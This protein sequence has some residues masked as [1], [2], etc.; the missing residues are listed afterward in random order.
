MN[1]TIDS[2]TAGPSP[3]FARKRLKTPGPAP[4]DPLTGL[5]EMPDSEQLA[6]EPWDEFHPPPEDLLEAFPWEPDAAASPEICDGPTECVDLPG[7]RFVIEDAGGSD[8]LPVALNRS[9]TRVFGIPGRAVA[10]ELPLFAGP[11]GGTVGRFVIIRAAPKTPGGDGGLFWTREGGPGYVLPN[12]IG[13]PQFDGID[14]V[15][16]FGNPIDAFRYDFAFTDG[17]GHGG[18]PDG[19]N[20]SVV[21][22]GW[23]G[24]PPTPG[25]L[26]RN[27]GNSSD[28]IGAY[29][30]GRGETD[31][32]AD[33]F[34][35]GAATAAAGDAPFRIAALGGGGEPASAG[36]GGG[37]VE[38]LLVG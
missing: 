12:L 4:S 22:A 8:R 34:L 18:P 30:P 16:W 33:E 23:S 9:A 19:R 1:R 25:L 13:R 5:P 3:A 7:H 10:W 28:L 35:R 11:T 24:G 32:R 15:A 20:S 6:R 14:P 36:H 17:G 37:P 26:G 21:F 2:G 38:Y 29:A 31:G 27:F